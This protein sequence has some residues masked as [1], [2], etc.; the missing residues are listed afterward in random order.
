MSAAVEHHTEH[1]VLIDAPP[2]EVY[3][4]IADVTRWPVAFT[5]TVHAEVL[6]TVAHDDGTSEELIHLWAQANGE[7]KDWTSRRTLDPQNLRVGFRQQLSA[8]PVAA[9]GG[10]WFAEPSG[11]GGTLVRLTH[12][13]RAVDDSPEHREWIARAVESNSTAELARLKDVVENAVADGEEVTFSFEDSVTVAGSAADLFDFV[14]RADAWEERLPHVARVDFTERPGGVQVLEMDTRAPDGSVH[15][16]RSVRLSLAP[17]RIVYKQLV[18]PGLLAAHTGLWTFTE[19][20]GGVVATSRHTVTVIP[21]KVTA[22]L[23]A[24]R[25]LAD[26]K[27]YVRKALGTNSLATLGLAKAYAESRATLVEAS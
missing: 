16:T 19:T 8:H 18:L 15:T 9:M 12:D 13:Y 11:D 6:E 5:P 22:V 21:E 1:T 14:D 2:S 24:D 26:A 10:D 23:G 3:A 27:A 4:V 25:T 20:D 17:D 7:V